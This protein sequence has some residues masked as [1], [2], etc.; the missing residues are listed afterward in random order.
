MK[1]LKKTIGLLLIFSI[2]IACFGGC[3]G[4]ENKETVRKYNCYTCYDEKKIACPNCD[5]Y[6]CWSCWEGG[7]ISTCSNCDGKGFMG[8]EYKKCSNCGGKGY[9]SSNMK[10]SHCSGK[11]YI[12]TKIECGN[13]CI[14]GDKVEYLGCSKCGAKPGY[15]P[16]IANGPWCGECDIPKDT[17]NSDGCVNRGGY[18]K[19]DCPDC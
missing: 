2:T 4:S 18:G 19:I 8:Y 17:T 1:T 13:R 16:T 14:R 9:N 10:C 7:T 5:A 15:C 3:K 6:N 11:G 12:S